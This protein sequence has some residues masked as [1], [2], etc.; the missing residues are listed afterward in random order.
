M[1]WVALRDAEDPTTVRVFSGVC[2]VDMVH[3]STL[4][5]HKSVVGAGEWV[6]EDGKLKRISANSGHFRPTMDRLVQSVRAMTEAHQPDTTVFL[7]N[8]KTGAWQNV[9]VQDFLATPSQGGAMKVH[10]EA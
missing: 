7:W 5:G 8:T 2:V 3:H 9:P 4:A 1:M 6:V 10:P